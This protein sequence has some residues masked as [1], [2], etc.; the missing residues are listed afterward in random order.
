M[1]KASI[2]FL[3]FLFAL[4]TLSQQDPQKQTITKTDYL[5]KSKTQKKIGWILIGG[6]AALIATSLV[7]P[8]GESTGI[9]ISP[10]NGA[11]IE[12]HKNDGVKA[13]FGLSGL[14]SMLA[15]I[16]LF[17]AS[18]KNKRRAANASV[19]IDSEQRPVLRGTA[20]NNQSFPVIAVR[21]KF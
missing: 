19:F 20:I 8:K 17:I 6:G 21:L 18:G 7:I 4:R 14:T 11:F 2:L 15:S 1:K 10:I 9:E 12:G 3:L 13:A 5:Q 16:P